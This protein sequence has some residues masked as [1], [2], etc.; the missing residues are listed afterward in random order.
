MNKKIAFQ[1][2]LLLVPLGALICYWSV[3]SRPPKIQILYT[4]HERRVPRHT[5]ASANPP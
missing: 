5:N 2:A 1:I 3:M 4:L